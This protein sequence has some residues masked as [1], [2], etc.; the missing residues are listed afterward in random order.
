MSVYDRWHRNEGDKP[1]GE[2]SR[3]KVKI[4]PTAE[5]GCSKRW[6][7]RWRDDQGRQRKQA[8]ERKADAEQFDAKVKTQLA[9]GSYV[10]PSAGQVTFRA[11]AEQWRLGRTHDLSTAER[12]EVALRVHAYA[13]EG[14]L[15]KTT[16]GGPAIG[17]YPMR[18]LA[19]RPSLIQAWIKGLSLHPNTA[20]KVIGDV[21]QVF[22]AAVEDGI[23]TRNPLAAKSVQLPKPV[24]TEAVPWT[25]PQVAAVAAELP[26]RLAALPY[27]GAACGPRQGELFALALCD[28]DFLRK[29][30]RIDTQVKYAGGTWYWAPVKN[31]K[32]RDVPVTGRVIPVLAEH[33][34]LFP[35]A[36]VTLPWG[37]PDGKP[38]ARTLLFTWPGDE[39]IKRTGFNPMWIRAWKRAG[40]PDRGRKNG[41]HVL[42]HTAAS[43]WLSAGLGLAK[44]AAYLGD[45]QEVVLRTYSHFMPGD[46]DRAR[47][48]MDAFFAAAEDADQAASAPDVPGARR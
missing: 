12:I 6:Q 29:M 22:T 14:T 15:G 10:D 39:A 33:V 45:T 1:C 19:K 17:D 42:R 35:P 32:A 23:L 4:Y 13:A 25:A 48:I 9:D 3:G 8:F 7:V 28:V 38:V 18:V 27:L 5:H 30:L 44:V 34:R 11:Y 20:R 31:G 43:A 2:H 36:E 24:K 37:E 40:I 41:C 26:P 47:D 16:T 21:S 46:D